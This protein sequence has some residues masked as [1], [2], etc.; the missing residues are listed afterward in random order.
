MHFKQ[1][2]GGWPCFAA[3]APA[4]FHPSFLELSTLGLILLNIP[5]HSKSIISSPNFPYFILL[6]LPSYY[7]T[8]NSSAQGRGHTLEGCLESCEGVALPKNTWS[9]VSFYHCT[10]TLSKHHTCTLMHMH[11]HTIDLAILHP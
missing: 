11:T 10:H 2:Y 5:P 6:P 4:T 8:L 7:S 3:V 9:D 1:P